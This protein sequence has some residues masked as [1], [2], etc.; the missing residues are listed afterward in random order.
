MVS[1]VICLFE[2]VLTNLRESTAD[3][4]HEEAIQLRDYRSH[5]SQLL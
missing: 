5:E 3:F 2:S 1:D 4:V